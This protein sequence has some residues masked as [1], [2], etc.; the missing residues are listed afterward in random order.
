M[1]V[2]QITGDDENLL[3]A[4]SL[5]FDQYRQFY[6]Q[7]SDFQ[8]AK[9]FIKSRLK[10]KESSVFLVQNQ[11]DK[12][13]GFMQLYFGFSSVGLR[14]II[15]LNDLYVDKNFRQLGVG[16]MLLDEAKKFAI[17]NNIHKITLA[18]G[19]ENETAQSLYTKEGYQKNLDYFT[20]DL[21]I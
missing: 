3:E 14:K 12:F 2:V 11:Q 4:A 18:T 5:L 19:K 17:Q 20:Y 15:I 21:E 9:E 7:N 16:K 13:V 6:Q 8:L 10:N 1:K